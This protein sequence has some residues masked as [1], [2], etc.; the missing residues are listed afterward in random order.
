MAKIW[1]TV[2]RRFW[3]TMRVSRAPQRKSILPE[4]SYQS[5]HT[6]EEKMCTGCGIKNIVKN[7]KIRLMSCRRPQTTIK[8]H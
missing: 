4:S 6:V 3:R 7:T 8:Q 1:C 5:R 2:P